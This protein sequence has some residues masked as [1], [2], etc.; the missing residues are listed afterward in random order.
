MPKPLSVSIETFE[1]DVIQTSQQKVVLVDFWA[2]WCPPCL[3]IA[4]ILEKIADQY[5]DELL[6]TKLEV[7]AGDGE[8]MKLAGRYKVRGFP[9]VILF[10]NG[11]EV[12][13][14]SGAKSQQEIESFIDN[15]T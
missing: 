9:T 15:N 13:R 3:V 8:N 5:G 4:P 1:Q 10:K 12:D 14:F 2:E 6:V 11:E 7:D